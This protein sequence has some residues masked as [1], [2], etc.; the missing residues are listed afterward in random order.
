MEVDKE[1][2]EALLREHATA[3][4]SDAISRWL[5]S[6]LFTMEN[7][8]YSES[9]FQ[10][11][12][13]NLRGL[14]DAVETVNSECLTIAP[15]E[16]GALLKIFGVSAMSK[17]C[18]NESLALLNKDDHEWYHKIVRISATLPDELQV[19][20]RSDVYDVST[21]NTD[22]ASNDAWL[23][24]PK[25]YSIERAFEYTIA[26]TCIYRVRMVRETSDSFVTMKESNVS[27]ARVK[28]IYELQWLD[29]KTA[30]EK[31]LSHV[32]RMSQILTNTA[33]PLTK[34]RAKEVIEEYR[35]LIDK[36][37]E[38]PSAWRR[39]AEY[40]A[41]PPFLAPKPI[42]LEKRHLVEESA[43]TYGNTSIW[44]GYCVTDKADG[45]RMLLFV[46]K[47]GDAYFINNDLEVRQASF[48]LAS[49]SGNADG[50]TLLD[51]EYIPSS[52]RKDGANADLF[53]AF[54]VYFYEG[55]PVY[56]YPLVTKH[57]T[58]ETGTQRA[59]TTRN[60]VRE[61]TDP[62]R[63]GTT[64]YDILTYACAKRQWRDANGD[65]VAHEIRSKIHS[66]AEGDNMRDA[67]RALLEGSQK[68]PYDI[69]G[70][71]FT[72]AGL[73]VCAYYPTKEVKFPVSLRWDLTLKWKPAEQNTIDFLV[74]EAKPPIRDPIT[75]NIFHRFNLYTGYNIRQLQPITVKEGL[76]MRYTPNARPSNDEYIRRIF[77]PISYLEKGVGQA[78][79]SEHGGRGKGSGQVRCQDGSIL[80]SDTIVEFAYDATEKGAALPISRRW[81]P[82]RVR[83]DKTRTHQRG[84]NPSKPDLAVSKTANDFS[85]ATSIWR[86]IHN[87]VTVEMLTNK[88]VM[89]S[90][91]EVP[92]TLEERLLG[93]DD[94]YYAREVPRQ[95]M[96]S[97]HMLNFHN[98]GVKSALYRYAKKHD[99]LLE[100]ACGKA[101]DMARW[102]DGEFSFVLGVDLAKDNICKPSDGAY[103]RV[104]NGQQVIKK[105][106]QD[107]ITYVYLNH[108]FAVGNCALPIHDGS[109]TDDPD[110]KELLRVLFKRHARDRVDPVYAHINGAA[111]NGFSVVSCQFAIHYFFKNETT[112]NGFLDNVAIN[113]KPGGVFIATFMDGDR[114]HDLLT[115]PGAG[116]LAEG[117]KL[118]GKALV[119]AIIKRYTT[120]GDGGSGGGVGAMN[121]YGKYIEVYLEN[122]GKLIPEFLVHL[123]TL[124]AKMK[125]R[126][127]EVADTE[128]FSHD[129]ARIMA[130]TPESERAYYDVKA[131]SNDPVQT[132]FSF[133]NR[134][135]VFRK[136]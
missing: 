75:G 54:D 69:D 16:G 74:E 102:K 122:T 101:G 47:S 31:V 86:S 33:L 84:K 112:L 130:S 88:S 108:V 40:K 60:E 39:P 87:P 42:T 19:P 8:A 73:G 9:T 79:V 99:S 5:F 123:P 96:L 91:A 6:F 89:V 110:S 82:L 25:H 51:G 56:T 41:M 72:P 120:F 103:A 18:L 43:H 2:F 32:A 30:P 22:V 65:A 58:A 93:V 106:I 83:E 71:V 20:V 76:R 57:T 121:V 134:W 63:S 100:L 94:V 131:L 37:T 135:I 119:W 115:R 62:K 105:R 124:V 78:F 7:Q 64:R 34:E 107:R 24:T 98:N 12:I 52:K 26:D 29:Y 104:I 23:A 114:V 116:G 92:A 81:I 77:E 80:A 127:L 46:T 53:A 3:A 11:V 90:S 10:W 128:L 38:K 61:T 133:L 113:L 28:Y 17:Y 44:K 129:F 55:K 27:S 14:E 45:E 48:R 136:M 68:L 117:R 4:A 132:Q 50:G 125:E 15:T 118:D 109:C 85:V 13:S 59:L 67:C 49:S 70:L 95:H 66:F 111:A 36:H 1:T 21:L 97:V 35:I 126:G